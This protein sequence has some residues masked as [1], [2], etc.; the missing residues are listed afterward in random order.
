MDQILAHTVGTPLF[1]EELTKM[2]LEGGLLRERDGNY[3]LEGPLPPLAI[4][5]SRRHLHFAELGS[6]ESRRW[7]PSWP[8][9]ISGTANILISSK[10]KSRE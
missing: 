7:I 8:C 1:I 10:R 6:G 2:V 4:P 5:T 3:L 9:R